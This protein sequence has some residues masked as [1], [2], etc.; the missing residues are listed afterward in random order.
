M[1]APIL[2][3]IPQ[4]HSSDCGVSVL[5]MLLGVTYEEALLAVGFEQPSV[6]TSGVYAKHLTQ[7]AKT[8][9]VTLRV[10]RRFDLED[11]TGI[12][13]VNSAK[14]TSAHVVILREG[15]IVDTDGTL[16]APDVYQRVH[17][18][19]FGPLLVREG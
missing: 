17:G 15:L 5:A 4:R 1:E 19:K 10:R 14:W 3:V 13:G 2:R 18:A 7:A 6:L 16:W 9:G 11:D 8:L 12:L